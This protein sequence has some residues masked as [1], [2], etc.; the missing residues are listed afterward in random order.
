MDYL[1]FLLGLGISDAV[2]KT[3]FLFQNKADISQFS[4][5]F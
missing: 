3:S 1:L 5:I 4:F 2:Y